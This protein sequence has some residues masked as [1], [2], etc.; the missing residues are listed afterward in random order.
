MGRRMNS[1]ATI[2][3]LLGLL[4]VPVVHSAS[5]RVVALDWACAETAQALGVTPVG[6]AQLAD[7]RLWSGDMP[8]PES[9]V[10]VG[11][12]MEPNLELIRALRPDLILLSPMQQ[13]SVPL[14]ERIAPV[15]IIAF[16]TPEQPDSY[17]QARVATRQLARLLGRPA[18]GERLLRA[19]EQA[20]TRLGERLRANGEP[21][22]VY[23]LR[24]AD[25]RHGWVLG[26]N[27]LFGG[28]LAAAGVTL[29]WRQQTNLWGCSTVPLTALM[30]EPEAVVV[31]IAPLPFPSMAAL[32]DNQLWR[33]LPAVREGR[34]VGLPPVWLGNGLPSLIAF[35]R[36]LAAH[37]PGGPKSPRESV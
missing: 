9:V 3:M 13:A 5:L 24:F 6:M 30:A 22:P 23:L 26:A 7:Y 14:L 10:D 27:S 25:R 20:L 15:Q 31:Y 4:L 2:V 34:L 21:R 29:A 19:T 16:N 32:D 11:L 18:Q 17:Q 1:V 8:M 36:L 35:S 33:R 12:R 37:W 28:G